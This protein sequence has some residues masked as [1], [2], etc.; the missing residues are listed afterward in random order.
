MTKAD[1]V[2]EIAKNTG[3]DRATV[4]TT[5]EAF[6]ETVKGSLS[7]DEN[8]YLRGFVPVLEPA[9]DE[10]VGSH[11]P[12]DEVGA[13]LNHSLVDEFPEW[14]LLAYVSQ[15]IKELV[16]ETGIDQVAGRVLGS[17]YIE[18]DI[19]PVGISILAHE[20]IVVVRI[21]VTEVIGARTGK[22]RH[23]ALLERVPV[24]SP[25]FRPSKRRFTRLGRL[26]LADFRKGDRQ[27]GLRYRARDSVLV[28]NWERLTPVALA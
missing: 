10:G 24:P 5:L 15:V 12:V 20:G 13:S 18:V 19:A 6:M 21:H 17:S 14:L 26:E 27:F 23:C 2:N 28:I 11:Y 25:V 7:N 4:L 9:G 22:A 8:V 3:I 1:I 16:P